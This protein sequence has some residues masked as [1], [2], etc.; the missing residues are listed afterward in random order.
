MKKKIFSKHSLK[1][2][3]ENFF[4]RESWSFGCF[5]EILLLHSYKEADIVTHYIR[6]L[7]KIKKE[8]EGER[9]EKAK[10]ALNDY[11]EAS[12]YFLLF[13]KTT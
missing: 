4:K 2:F 9:K 7:K 1:N 3:L 11:Y 8:S 5:R 6:E 13:L 12:I 10:R